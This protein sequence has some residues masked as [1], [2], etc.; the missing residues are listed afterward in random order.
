MTNESTSQ[1]GQP[2]EG[3]VNKPIRPIPIK[4]R[5]T[6]EAIGTNE[7]RNDEEQKD[8][9]DDR[10]RQPAN[11][12]DNEKEDVEEEAI[13]ANVNR[14]GLSQGICMPC[15][16]EVEE[17]MICHLPFRSWCSHCV[18][19]KGVSGRH[20][21]RNAREPGELSQVHWDYGYLTKKERN[22][23]QVEYDKRKGAPM[24]VMCDQ[25]TDL[26]A[27]DFVDN[28]GVTDMALRM[29]KNFIERLGHKRVI[30]RSDQEPAITALREELK[31][32]TWVEIVNGESQAYD[33][34]TNGK[35]ESV[36]QRVEKQFRVMR[37]ALE[38]RIKERILDRH[39]CV[40]FLVNHAAKCI[41]RYQKG[42]DGKT[43]N[44]RWRG[45]EFEFDTAEFGENVDYLIANSRKTVASGQSRWAE[46]IMLGHRDE[47][48]E[49]IIGTKN[50]IVKS[51]Q[52]RRKHD[53]KERWSKEKL[54]E[55]RGTRWQPN[56]GTNDSEIHVEVRIPTSEGE[57]RVP[58]EGHDDAQVRRP[59]LTA[60]DARRRG[61]W[62]TRCPGCRAISRN[63]TKAVGHSEECRKS[64][65]LM[66]E[67]EEYPRYLIL[68][69]RYEHR[70]TATVVKLS[71]QLD[72]EPEKA[73]K[74][75]VKRKDADTPAE[76]LPSAKSAKACSSDDAV[77]VD[78]GSN[79]MEIDSVSNSQILMMSHV[80]VSEPSKRYL[81]ELLRKDT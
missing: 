54:D 52:V 63:D 48:G 38:S 58:S 59:K 23:S 45:K 61:Q 79:N 20:L 19:G 8:E 53:M 6:I 17:H 81:K 78:D 28:K 46:G 9:G 65:E 70:A 42:E 56:P 4:H 12:S 76:A 22:E 29:T 62:A 7:G 64:I 50:G 16:A 71:E 30:I 10:E 21:R 32:R 14:T 3:C 49:A 36:V 74:T 39:N 68:K 67:K 31:R 37:D 5:K 55:M 57:F 25:F 15:A 60:G 43:A 27:A 44:K 77:R 11:K 66:L 75:G 40:G 18:R 80:V 35:I 34:Q 2:E 73:K 69:A 1:N 33:S 26:I 24:L 13:K 72:R 41:N 51:G 47:S